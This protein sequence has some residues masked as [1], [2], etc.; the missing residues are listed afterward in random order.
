MTVIDLASRR[1]R[2]A[3]YRLD[4]AITFE[5]DG[6]IQV[7]IQQIETPEQEVRLREVVGA[8][9]GQI[10]TPSD[11]HAVMT[12][13]IETFLETL[14]AT[15]DAERVADVAPPEWTALITAAAY[16]EQV[17]AGHPSTDGDA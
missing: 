4:L 14:P 12:L 11:V 8:L 17:M 10:L 16:Y 9:A 15:V 1:P 2:P 3:P 7:H 6:R 13:R 5:D